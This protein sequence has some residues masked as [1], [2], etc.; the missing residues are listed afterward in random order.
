MSPATKGVGSTPEPFSPCLT[1][2]SQRWPQ[3]LRLTT[4]VTRKEVNL[5]SPAG[6]NPE[7]FAT[8]TARAMLAEMQWVAVV[9]RKEVSL[10]SPPDCD[11]HLRIFSASIAPHRPRR[12]A[13]EEV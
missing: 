5:T 3:I 8:Q 4:H 1:D 10:T 9:T 2:T 6:C 7:R 12:A 13:Q 11:P